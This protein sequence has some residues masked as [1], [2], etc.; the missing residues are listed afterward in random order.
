M[1]LDLAKGASAGASPRTANRLDEDREGDS[2]LVRAVT[3]PWPGAFTDVFGKKVTIWK[4]R[5]APYAGHDV[6]PGYRADGELR[7]RLLGRRPDGGTRGAPKAEGVDA[8]GFRLA[9]APVGRLS[10]T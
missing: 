4:T 6:F 9:H 10:R 5:I 2:R 7:R 1:P 8:G 3:K